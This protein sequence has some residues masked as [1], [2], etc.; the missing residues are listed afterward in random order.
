MSQYLLTGTGKYIKGSV[1]NSN[2]YMGWELGFY[3][4]N[5]LC[6]MLFSE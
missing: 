1:D 2:I 6:H 5:M 3:K 4:A